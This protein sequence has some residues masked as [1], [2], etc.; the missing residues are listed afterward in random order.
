MF[1][2]RTWPV[3]AL[4]AT[5]LAVGCDDEKH[6]S[7]CPPMTSSSTASQSGGRTMYLTDVQAKG[8]RCVDRITFSFRKQGTAQPGYTVHYLPAAQATVEDGSGRKLEVAGNAFLVVRIFPAAT[9]LASGDKLEFTYRGKR[10]QPTGMR[11]VQ[12]I[13]KTGDFEAVVTWAIGLDGKRPFRLSGSASK[14]GFT[15]EIG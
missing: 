6:V 12:E 10:L 9:A 11:H 1:A 8:D 4:T 2:S 7:S 3:A 14:P 13:V 15:V 5:L